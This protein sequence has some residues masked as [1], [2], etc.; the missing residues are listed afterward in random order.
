M[1]PRSA[2]I[3][4]ISQSYQNLKI[5]VTKGSGSLERLA[6]MSMEHFSWTRRIVQTTNAVRMGR[7]MWTAQTTEAI[8]QLF[9]FLAAK[10]QLNKS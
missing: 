1:I 6:R 2:S 3:S 8:L 7:P 5:L 10:T 4:N 9:G